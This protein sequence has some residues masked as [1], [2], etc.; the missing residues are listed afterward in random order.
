MKRSIRLALALAALVPMVSQAAGWHRAYVVE[1]FEPAFYYGAK[2]GDSAPGTDCPAGTNPDMDWRKELKTS[3]RTEAD[4]E[5]I[6]DPEKPLRAQ[7]GGIRG[8]NQENVYEKPWSVP[9]PGMT[10]VTGKL[11]YGFDLDGK[12]K[13]GFLGV[14]GEK[15]IDNQYY[16]AAGCWTSWRGPQRGSHHA[17]YVNDGM[18]DGVFSVLM[19]VSGAGADWRN[20]ND[21]T[22]GFYLSKDK[23]VKDANGDIAR[24]YSFRLTTDPRYQSIVK[25]RTV[26]GVI[27]NTER[28]EVRMH[29]IET[30]PFFPAQLLLHNARLRFEP[31]EDGTMF[32]MVGGYRPIDDYYTGWAAAGAIHE[33]TT[34]VNMPAYWYSLRRNA[35]ATPDPE[36]GQNTEI[37]TAYQFYLQPA[38]VIAPNGDE[39]VTVAKL[40]DGPRLPDAPTRMLPRSPGGESSNGGGA[41]KVYP[42]PSAKAH[43]TRN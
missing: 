14:N 18:R 3:Y 21:V 27:E 41:S 33:L 1:W 15:G 30:A 11:A 37:S 16:K 26:K 36:T 40:F 29:D 17:K 22:V 23:M 31:K 35:D 43:L 5:K 42:P 38:F 24:D 34:H 12:T 13:T 2:E 7:V 6:L 28:A 10:G 39:P 25:A 20:D 19:V 4:V 9:D 32:G 8:P